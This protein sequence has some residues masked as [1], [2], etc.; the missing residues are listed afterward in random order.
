MTCI[1]VIFFLNDK[2]LSSH[3][4]QIIEHINSLNKK[5]IPMIKWSKCLLT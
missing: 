1:I 2:K 4:T 3:M 5:F